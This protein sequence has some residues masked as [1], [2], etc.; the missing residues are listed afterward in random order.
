[1]KLEL[2]EKSR[3]LGEL[4]VSTDEYRAVQ[5]AETVFSSDELAQGKVKD[6]NDLQQ[7]LQQMMQTAEPDQSAIG[8]MANS[9]REMQAELTELPA[10]TAMNEAQAAFSTLLNQVNQVL[11]FVITGEVDEGSDCGG[12]CSSCASSCGGHDDGCDC[13]D[14]NE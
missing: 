11:R 4:L 2:F 7:T 1:M 8:A 14:C 3:E 5:E 12:N 6:F 9:L 10:I 13:E